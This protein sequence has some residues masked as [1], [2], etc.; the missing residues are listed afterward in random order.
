M[1]N[2][3]VKLQ[4]NNNVIPSI[5]KLMYSGFGNLIATCVTVI[6]CWLPRR[7]VD[8]YF[9]RAD[10]YNILKSSVRTVDHARSFFLDSLEINTGLSVI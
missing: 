8:K 2:G 5:N 10:E 4:P 7:H 3:Y 1:D 9:G 6:I